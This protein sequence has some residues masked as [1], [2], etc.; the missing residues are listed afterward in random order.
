MS[1]EAIAPAAASKSMRPAVQ[2]GL[3]A[4][5]IA[6][7]A[8]VA[9]HRTGVVFA[10]WDAQAHL[11]IARRV[12]DSITPGLQMLGTVWLPVPHLLMLPLVGNNYLWR[13]G[14]AGA[15]PS[16]I[17]FVLAGTF[18]FAAARRA[19]QSDAAAMAAAGKAIS[20]VKSMANEPMTVPR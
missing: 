2:A 20:S 3:V 9:A 6:V 13:T 19:F 5:I 7:A 17:F 18:L 11:D 8:Q 10:F 15:I 4:F 12:V 1:A 16:A 14:L